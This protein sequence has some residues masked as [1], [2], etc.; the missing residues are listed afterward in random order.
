VLVDDE[1]LRVARLGLAHAT[2]IVLA[3]VLGLA[4]VSAPDAMER[5]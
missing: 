5:A 4:G 2:K 1:D 3:L